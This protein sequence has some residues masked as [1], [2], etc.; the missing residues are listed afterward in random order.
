MIK[1]EG[2]WQLYWDG[3]KMTQY[4]PAPEDL[5]KIYLD[6]FSCDEDCCGVIYFLII[7]L[8]KENGPVELWRS[9]GFR[10]F[11]RSKEE[12]DNFRKNI[13]QAAY[14]CGLNVDLS[15]DCVFDW[16]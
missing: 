7:G 14:F 3:M 13:V 15:S 11:D 12:I 8:T 2:L 1:Q 9:E 16:E 10:Y 6:S 5:D 4:E